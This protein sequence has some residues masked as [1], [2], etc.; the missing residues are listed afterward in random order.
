MPKHVSSSLGYPSQQA[1]ISEQD[2]CV[3]LVSWLDRLGWLSK[4]CPDSQ[5]CQVSMGEKKKVKE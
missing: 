5:F 1:N 4:H 3:Q 2:R